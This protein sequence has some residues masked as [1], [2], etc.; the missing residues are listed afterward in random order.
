L[1]EHN[2]ILQIKYL[3]FLIYLR[4]FS[5]ELKTNY[6]QSCYASF[7][8]L[9]FLLRISSQFARALAQ[10]FCSYCIERVRGL[11]EMTQ[12]NS[13]QPLQAGNTSGAIPGQDGASITTVIKLK[14]SNYSNTKLY[15]FF[16]VSLFRLCLF[17]ESSSSLFLLFHLLTSLSFKYVS[18]CS[19]SLSLSLS[20][21]RL[22]AARVVTRRRNSTKSC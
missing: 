5:T 4:V 7:P 3:N 2:F 11:W 14:L 19:L 21:F 16:S 17:L 10:K 22:K 12:H 13:C 8:I 20:Y 1:C 6:A 18:R 15:S 9:A